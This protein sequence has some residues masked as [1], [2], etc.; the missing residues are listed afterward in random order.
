[1]R[2]SHIHTT[3]CGILLAGMLCSGTALAQGPALNA[4]VQRAID[5]ARLRGAGVG[6][7]AVEVKSGR[8]LCSINDT[9]PLILASNMK[10]LTTGTALLLLGEKF[11]FTTSLHAVGKVT[12]QGVLSGDLVLVAGGDPA[13]S[14]RDYGGKTTAVFDAWAAAVA[15]KI[16]RVTGDL[17]IDG[18]IFDRQYIHP[19]WP[20]DQLVRWYCAPVSAFALN[21]NCIDVA[22]R[23]GA[24]AGS[25]ARVILDPPTKY[26]RV[27]NR[28]RT[29]GSGSSRAII[30]RTAGRDELV[31]SG[32]LTPRS[33]G[34][35]S[36]VTVADPTR[37]AATV[38]KERLAKAG[39]TID[40]KIVLAAKR[41]KVKGG[42]LLAQTSHSLLNAATV[43]N[44]RSQNFYAEMIFKT[45]G[46]RVADPST[47]KDGARV[48][49]D[50]L[51]QMG[52]RKDRV[53]ISDGSGMSRLNAVA[54]DQLVVFLRAMALS[55]V[56]DPFIGSLAVSGKRGTLR[57]RM[58][59]QPVV[60]RVLAKT[61][62][63]RGVTTLSGYVKANGKLVA[64]SILINGA[65]VTGRTGD[66][67]Q[68]R[69]CR[70]IV[71]S[72]R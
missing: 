24:R 22:V 56:A 66:A 28:C 45:L 65:R 1:M 31:I 51:V 40:G 13:I 29:V 67:L 30:H 68:D 4:P 52:L 53:T 72:M 59:G 47:F 46:R 44:T 32:K 12:G 9:R 36:P 42:V 49:T 7:C 5:A 37:F 19:N 55:K 61:G 43:A 39:V 27:T 11:Q 41:V 48:V 25:P 20:K 38:L 16:R 69:I 26:F 6:V 62:H 71:D 34:A 17:V 54:P 8:L 23:P 64:F 18:T 58:T 21:D 15:R 2:H 14:G 35:R 70:L 57:R 50:K 33:A 3:L 63:L 10:L 60:G